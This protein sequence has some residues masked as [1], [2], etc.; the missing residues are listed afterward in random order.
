MRNPSVAVEEMVSRHTMYLKEMQ[1]KAREGT[2]EE[3]RLS[4]RVTV[5]HGGR[6]AGSSLGASRDG[7]D[8]SHLVGMA[9]HRST[10]HATHNA[11]R[12][13]AAGSTWRL[14]LGKHVGLLREAR[15]LLM[16]CS[17]EF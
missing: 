4:R 17:S 11:Q 13:L 10:C 15:G 7:P 16:R 3:M 2:A 12:R 14:I 1:Q 9:T 5:L 8:G 6:R